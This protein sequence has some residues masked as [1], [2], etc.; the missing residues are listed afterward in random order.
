MIA[1]E[2]ELRCSIEWIAKMYASQDREAVEPTWS[3]ETRQ[4]MAE[5]TQSV[6]LKIEREVAEYL[7]C[8]YGYL[9]PLREEAAPRKETQGRAL[10]EQAA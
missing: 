9:T 5:Q 7:A 8:K 1:D 4:E 3:P 10:T 2:L 6:R